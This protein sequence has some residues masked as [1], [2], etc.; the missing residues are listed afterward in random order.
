MR[1]CS[2]CNNEIPIEKRADAK[3]CSEQCRI[4]FN[5][6][7]RSNL[8][9]EKRSQGDYHPKDQEQ[10]ESVKTLTLQD[11]Q[12]EQKN[13]DMATLMLNAINELNR[14]IIKNNELLENLAESGLREKNLLTIQQAAD[15]FGVSTKTMYSLVKEDKVQSK[16]VGRKIYIKPE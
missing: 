16:R 11:F 9:A 8:R 6:E 12:I 10:D 4:D 15:Y 5:M 7:K 2:H 14:N 3:F 13:E 1:T